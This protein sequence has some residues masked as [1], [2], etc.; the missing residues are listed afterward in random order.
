[1]NRV[2]GI[3]PGSRIT[4]YGVVDYEINRL[5]HIASG[6]LRS[7]ASTL[8]GRLQEIFIG[9]QEAVE[10][11][12][13]KEV[14]IERV[15]LHRNVASALKLGHARGVAIVAATSEALPVYEYSATQ[16]KQAT[17]GRGRASKEQV[18]HMVRVL[19][20]LDHGLTNDASD[21]LAVALCH[22]HLA[23]T[24]HQ[25]QKALVAGGNY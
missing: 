21:A 18:Q 11:Y 23:T 16:V 6:Q 7:T 13:P 5:R 3:D 15:F 9:L 24:Y 2:L 25:V 19:L 17:T 22:S 1:M 12:Q 8:A 14:A 20:N 10:R 4:G